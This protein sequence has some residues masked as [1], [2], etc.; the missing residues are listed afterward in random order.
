MEIREERIGQVVVLNLE[1]KLNNAAYQPL[2]DK[3]TALVQAGEK[4]V[5]VDMSKV[6]FMSSVGLRVFFMAAKELQRAEG[7]LTVCAPP[8]EIRRTFEISG[9]PTPYPIAATLAE[10]LVLFPK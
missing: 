4:F 9:F 5:L 7:M 10:A 2:H 6:N 3:F 1:G 8:P